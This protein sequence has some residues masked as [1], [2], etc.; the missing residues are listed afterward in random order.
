MTRNSLTT[1]DRTQRHCL[2]QVSLMM[3]VLTMAWQ[4][5]HM[6]P[7]ASVV[8]Q[9]WDRQKAIRLLEPL[10][11]GPQQI[12]RMTRNSLTTPDRTQRYCL[13]QVP[14]MRIVPTMAWQRHHME[15]QASMMSQTWDQ[16]QAIRLL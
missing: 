3:M 15:R 8:L 6:E 16:K 5:H 1:L 9:T 11:R 2:A 7:Q 4:C 12:V 14:L 10:M 13:D